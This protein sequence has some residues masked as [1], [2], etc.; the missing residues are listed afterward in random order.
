ML[1]R[2]VELEARL[3]DDLLDLTRIAKGK[4]QLNS[5]VVD[6]HDLLGSVKGICQSEINAKQ[7]DSKLQ[8][9]ATRHHVLADSA[10]LQPVFW[11]I[12]RNAAKFTADGGHVEICTR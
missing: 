3:I 10:R 8:L 2:N 1:R 12:L 5:E 7:I 9:A 6:L 11:N 4:I